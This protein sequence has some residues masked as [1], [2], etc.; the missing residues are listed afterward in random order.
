MLRSCDLRL[1]GLCYHRRQHR[2]NDR[3]Y[4]SPISQAIYL[5]FLVSSGGRNWLRYATH[6]AY[7]LSNLL[8]LATCS[9]PC[10]GLEMVTKIRLTYLDQVDDHYR[11]TIS[12]KE[13]VEVLGG[14]RK[15]GIHHADYA[16]SAPSNNISAY[17]LSIGGRGDILVVSC[18]QCSGIDPRICT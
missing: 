6:S 15:E 9:L 13:I 17:L 10:E 14:C 5:I 3:N 8:S 11:C 16:R 7:A 2:Q 1:G 12:L 18:V 4:Y